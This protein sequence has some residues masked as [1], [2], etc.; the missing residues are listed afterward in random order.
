MNQDKL[1]PGINK[2]VF[3]YIKYNQKILSIGC[4]SGLLEAEAKKRG[5]S[6]Y[7]LDISKE[8]VKNASK[9]MDGVFLCDLE[10][11]EQLPFKVETF[12][13]IILGD[14]I[15]HLLE[16]GKM[17]QK[18][19]PYLKKDGYIVASIPNVANWTVRIPLLFGRFTYGEEGVVVWQHYRFFTRKSACE[20][21]ENSGYFLETVDCTTSVVNVCYDS[22]KRIGK[23][24]DSMEKG[25]QEKREASDNQRKEH[26]AIFSFFKN[27]IKKIVETVDYKVTSLFMGLFAFQFII[28]A[29]RKE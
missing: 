12:D 10:K 2:G 6:V 14:V 26:S 23:R 9:V 7:G 5:N 18:I 11:V 13:V 29:K 8:N 21:I 20:L 28:V 1:A 17:L 3:K 27:L 19:K 16:P 25:R 22:I 4:G 24:Y 15:E